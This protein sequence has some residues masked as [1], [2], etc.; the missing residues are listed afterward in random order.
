MI[1]VLL[2]DDHTIVRAGLKELLSE[3]GDITVSGEANDGAEAL[4]RIRESDYD[5]AVLDMSMPG[6]SGIELIRQVKRERPRLPILVLSMH[7]EEQYAVRALK[8]G[9]TGYLTKESAA[10]QLVAAIRRIAAGGAFV[11]PETAQRLALDVNAAGAAAP[12]TLLSDREFQVLRLIADGKSV[13]EI[14]KQLTLSVKTISTHKTRIMR[15]MRLANQAELIRYAIEHELLDDPPA[16][17]S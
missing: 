6:R 8:A 7:S 14:A 5:V 4:A 11:T 12:H 9:A 16:S 2:A 13:S 15:K 1:T 10:D 3:T 17:H